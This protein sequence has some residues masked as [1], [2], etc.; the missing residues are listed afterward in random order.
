MCCGRCAFCCHVL[1]PFVLLEVKVTANECKVV[2]SDQLYDEV[3]LLV[4]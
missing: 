1:G 4:I 3:L 2:V